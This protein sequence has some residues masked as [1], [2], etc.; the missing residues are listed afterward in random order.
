MLKVYQTVNQLCVETAEWLVAE[1]K[2]TILEKGRFTVS[3]SGGSTPKALF[4]EL[5]KSRWQKQLDWSKILV[6]W[7]DERFVPATDVQSNQKMARETLLNHVP[8]PEKN[9][10]PIPFLATVD[11]SAK[12]YEAD[13][14]RIFVNLPVFDL[15][16][17]GLGSDGHTASLFPGSAA[18]KEESRWVCPSKVNAQGPERITLTYPVINH[19]AKV[20]FLVTGIEK[21][22]MVKNIVEPMDKNHAFPAQRICPASGELIW[23]LDQDAANLLTSN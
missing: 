2:R 14:K 19:A 21:A 3:L 10:F 12:Q 11:L 22:A 15:I 6:F 20:C 5:A 13:L 23:I 9:I 8:I 1:A 7:G 4:A 17:L 16:L 18:L